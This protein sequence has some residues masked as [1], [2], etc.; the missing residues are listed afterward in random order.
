MV[1]LSFLSQSCL[2]VSRSWQKQT[3]CIQF[4]TKRAKRRK[5]KRSKSSSSKSMLAHSWPRSQ[6]E[7]I[8]VKSQVQNLT[9]QKPH[10][11]SKSLSSLL[12]WWRCAALDWYTSTT[13]FP[14]KSTSSKLQFHLKWWEQKQWA[15]LRFAC[16]Y[17]C[18]D[19][20]EIF[21]LFHFFSIESVWFYANWTRLGDRHFNR[22]SI[23][24]HHTITV[25]PSLWFSLLPI[26]SNNVS[27]LCP[28]S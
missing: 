11:K 3:T 23:E 8:L 16:H 2:D 22:E 7:C 24:S 6:V 20:A 9:L 14:R 18:A 5:A 4:A 10:K 1:R 26:D 21:D 27:F 19:L 12:A 28:Y 15:D 17:Y 25:E 13:R